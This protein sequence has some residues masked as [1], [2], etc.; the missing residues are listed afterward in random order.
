MQF[1][2]IGQTD[3]RA[4]LYTMLKICENLGDCLYVTN[5]RKAQRLMEDGP[6]VSGTYRNIAIHVLDTTADDVWSDIDLAPDDFEFVFFDNLYNEDTDFV[7][8]IKG[9]G[10]DDV[11]LPTVQS[12]EPEE[13]ATIKMGKPDKVKKA[14]KGAPEHMLFNVPYSAGMMEAIEYCEF[15]K[16]LKP[17]SPAALKACTAILSAKKGI[18]QKTLEKV[19]TTKK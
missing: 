17:C 1:T 4:I 9:A 14:K 7:I 12:L 18:P 16:Q 13:Y 5:N 2:F 8:Y 11:D 19:A 15:F 6:D 3:N 10:D